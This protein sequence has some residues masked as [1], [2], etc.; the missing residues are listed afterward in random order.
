MFLLG[1]GHFV[2][3]EIEK[4]DSTLVNKLNLYEN[5]P[6]C[7]DTNAIEGVLEVARQAAITLSPS[8]QTSA[9]M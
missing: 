1:L 6:Q 5:C 7:D 3:L 4:L 9:K 8:E 2:L